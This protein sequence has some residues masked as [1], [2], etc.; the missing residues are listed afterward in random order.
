MINPHERVR[1]GAVADGSRL[2]RNGKDERYCYAVKE[3]VEI[4]I[5]KRIALEDY[6]PVV[7]TSVKLPL[8]NICGENYATKTGRKLGTELCI[9]NYRNV[10]KKPEFE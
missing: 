10:Y 5:M 7:E 8:A 6:D 1:E 9:V 4:V 3:L 2:R